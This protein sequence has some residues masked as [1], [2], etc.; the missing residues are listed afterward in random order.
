[1]LQTLVQVKLIA[2]A[3]ALGL[4]TDEWKNPSPAM[5]DQVQSLESTMS[6]I[7]TPDAEKVGARIQE[8]IGKIGK[9]ADEGD[10]DAQYAIAFFIQNGLLQSQNAAQLALSYYDKAAKAGQI[11]AKNALGFITIAQSNQL[12]EKDRAEAW[13]K[14]VEM[15]ED[16]SKAGY[17]PGKRNLAELK[18]TGQAGVAQDV[19]G[20]RKLLEEAA[21]GK[22]GQAAYELFR[23]YAGRAGKD[24]VDDAKAKQWLETSADDGNAQGLDTLGSALLAGGKIGK[25]EIKQNEKLAV[26]KFAKLAKDG[27]PVGL[28]KMALIHLGGLAKQEKNIEE[29]LK[30]LQQAARGNDGEAQVRLASML[31]TGWA[32][33]KDS[34]PVL[35]RND[36][37][38]LNLYKL[39][40]QNNIPM[41]AYNV[42]VFYEQGRAVDKDPTK[43]FAYY[44]QAAGANFVPAMLKTGL[45]Y[46]N[47]SGTLKDLIAAAGWFQRAGALGSPEGNLA[48]G[49]LYEQGAGPMEKDSNRYAMA[50]HCYNEALESVYASKGIEAEALVR[51]GGLSFTGVTRM[52]QANQTPLPDYVKAY[53]CFKQATLLV[54]DSPLAKQLLDRA[55]TELEKEKKGDVAKAETQADEAMKDRDSRKET[56]RKKAQAGAAPAAD[57]APTAAPVATPVSAPAGTNKKKTGKTTPP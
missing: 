28:R 41:A 50:W 6:L 22:D 52:T 39:A 3:A 36:A 56:E 7:G 37:E 45:A 27:N 26:E 19:D 10:K 23:Y 2:M 11:P 34:K 43:S 20:A 42:G 12:P 38:A 33:D 4:N 57:A 15:I 51:L 29:G 30:E 17:N 1:M 47:G 16:A 14:G 31:D 24:K 9:L 21:A 8:S 55:K 44:L 46:S 35:G 32:P 13:K 53:S 48:L 49:L 40:M 25:I 5:K 54:P 18:L